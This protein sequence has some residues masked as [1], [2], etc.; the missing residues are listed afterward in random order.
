MCLR[1]ASAAALRRAKQAGGE[2]PAVVAGVA[3][4]DKVIRTALETTAG[5]TTDLSRDDIALC[6]GQIRA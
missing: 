3:L 1:D 4:R 5:G 6:V 2:A